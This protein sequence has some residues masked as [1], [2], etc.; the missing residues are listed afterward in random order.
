MPRAY[1]KADPAERFWVKV[2]RSLEPDGCWEWAAAAGPL[3]Y[4]KFMVHDEG[5]RKKIVSAHRFSYQLLVGPIP[6]GLQ[7]DHLCR[8]PP[9]VRPS[10]LEPVTNR[11]NTLRG[12]RV[13]IMR[14]TNPGAAFQKTKTHCPRGHEYT[15]DNTYIQPCG[16]RGRRKPSTSRVCRTCR[17]NDQVARRTLKEQPATQ[18]WACFGGA[19]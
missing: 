9:C 4:G 16:N 18:A 8:N 12:A 14:D 7:L 17:R 19:Q 6:A 2:N 3:G 13:P 11:E 15:P 5:G 1:V 10:H